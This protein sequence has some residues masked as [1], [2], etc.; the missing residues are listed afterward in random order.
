MLCM[1][2]LKQHLLR[3]KK[4]V[5]FKFPAGMLLVRFVDVTAMPLRCATECLNLSVCVF[6]FCLFFLVPFQGNE[7]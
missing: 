6:G 5:D 3:R 7:V 1:F 2:Y 4:E